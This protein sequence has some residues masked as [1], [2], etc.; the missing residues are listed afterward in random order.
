LSEL[1]KI[2]PTRRF[3]TF[4]LDS[5]YEYGVLQASLVAGVFVAMRFFTATP[6]T[7]TQRGFF[8]RIILNSSELMKMTNGK[9]RA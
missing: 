3:F 8:H 4:F 9:I 1:K 7:T 2:N 6:Q 5:A